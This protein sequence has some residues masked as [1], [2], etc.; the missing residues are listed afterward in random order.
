MSAT[1]EQVAEELRLLEEKLSERAKKGEP[2]HHED[3]VKLNELRLKLQTSLTLNEGRS[4]LK[5]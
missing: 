2:I 1:S 4:V 5:G 3:K